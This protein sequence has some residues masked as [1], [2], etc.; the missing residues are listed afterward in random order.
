MADGDVVYRRHGNWCDCLE[1]EVLTFVNVAGKT[2]QLELFDFET[3]DSGRIMLDH[4]MLGRR[5]G[6]RWEPSNER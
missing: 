3:R 1:V 4:V 5:E 2:L 6:T